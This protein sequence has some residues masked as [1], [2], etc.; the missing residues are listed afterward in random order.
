MCDRVRAMVIAAVLFWASLVCPQAQARDDSRFDYYLLSLSWS[1]TYCLLH[2][3]DREQCTKGYG[4]VLHGLWP[5]YER[6]GYPH[7]CPTSQNLSADARRK[8]AEIFPSARLIAHEWF[9]HGSCAGL[10]AR[11]YF[12]Q[13]DKAFTQTK[14]PPSLEAPR[15]ALF[16]SATAI[17]DAFA[18]ANP[19]VPHDSYRLACRGQELVEVRICLSKDLKGRACGADVE[20]TC[21]QGPIRLRAVR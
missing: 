11:D 18:G 4:F 17:V 13:A 21:R 9:K 16:L 20:N 10:A 8:A 12:D 1:P 3:D 15:S 14:I 7:D 2:R 19:S 5:Q 6:G